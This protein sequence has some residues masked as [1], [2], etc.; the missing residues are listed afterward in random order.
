M[1]A[2][3]L[4]TLV[5][6]RPA[7]T[8]TTGITRM[9]VLLTATMALTT[10]W[11]ASLSV[12]A[13][14][15]MASTAAAGFTVAVSMVVASADAAL[16]DGLASAVAA[17]SMAAA[18][19]EAAQ[20]VADRLAVDSEAVRAASMAAEVSAAVEVVAGSTA[21][22]VPMVAVLTAADTGNIHRLSN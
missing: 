2:L 13:H 3:A 17:A 14:G 19:S 8:A 16:T 11:A 4:A 22:G 9:L 10:L 20:S 12:P 18:V 15:S 1:S 6:A 21:V 5:P 7:L